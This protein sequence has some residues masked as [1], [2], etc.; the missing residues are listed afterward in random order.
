MTRR[1][2]FSFQYSNDVWRANV[3]RNSWVAVGKEAAGFIDAAA[4]EKLKQTGDAAVQRWINEQMNGTSV[5]VVLVGAKTCESK[6]VKYEVEQSIKQGKGLLQINI[7]SINDQ[8]GNTSNF[9]GDVV[10][11]NYSRYLWF[12][13]EGNKNLG[14]W[15]EQAAQTA[16]R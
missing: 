3:V 11:S 2:F 4:F 10:P 15:I 16:G 9:C 8:S 14:T 6:W 7:S 12:S 13:G 1:V 5:T